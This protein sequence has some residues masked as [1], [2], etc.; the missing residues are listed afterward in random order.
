MLVASI[1]KCCVRLVL[2]N[3]EDVN[4]GLTPSVLEY[5]HSPMETETMTEGIA[6]GAALVSSSAIT[7][8]IC[9]CIGVC[10]QTHSAVLRAS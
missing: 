5:H 9:D 8:D 4:Y 6:V 3:R 2:W 1:G 7:A 10:D